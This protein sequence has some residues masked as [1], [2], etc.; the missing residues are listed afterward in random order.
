[1][2]WIFTSFVGLLFAAV[3]LGQYSVWFAMLK[4]AFMLALIV[5]AVLALALA[6]RKLK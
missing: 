4:I 1:M 3:S 5:I 2:F 6:S